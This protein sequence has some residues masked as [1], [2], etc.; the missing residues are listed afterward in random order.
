[1]VFEDF[2][3]AADR[4]LAGDK[5]L[6]SQRS[7]WKGGRDRKP[8]SDRSSG[9]SD[10][11]RHWQVHGTRQR[12]AIQ[13][14]TP[15]AKVVA[16]SSG[17]DD[18]VWGDD[19]KEDEAEDRLSRFLTLLRG[20]RF[21]RSRKFSNDE[22]RDVLSLTQGVVDY[23]KVAEALSTMYESAGS[24]GGSKKGK[25]KGGGRYRWAAAMQDESLV[26]AWP[27]GDG[28]HDPEA[29]D[30]EER[31]W[32]AASA[33]ASEK[34]EPNDETGKDPEKEELQEQVLKSHWAAFV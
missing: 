34:W 15:K 22:K 19:G 13:P 24:K 3:E 12:R 8:P 17:V 27:N 33:A 2:Q 5:V 6:P 18:D 20:Y 30:V 16:T 25:G 31:A 1:M 28:G 21:L 14:P 29:D 26:D 10:E 7:S 4:F 23:D 32:V 9:G 11:Q